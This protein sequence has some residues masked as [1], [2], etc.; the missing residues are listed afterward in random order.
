MDEEDLSRARRR[1]S[2]RFDRDALNS[3]RWTL[4][5][6]RS[7]RHNCA[8]RREGQPKRG[9]GG[10]YNDGVRSAVLARIDARRWCRWITR[11]HDDERTERA[12]EPTAFAPIERGR[13]R[14][15]A[16]RSGRR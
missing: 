5:K 7:T 10:C 4:E 8:K 15:R 9:Y 12:V 6:D 3:E 11:A 14:W 2:R 16:P 13:A 1:W